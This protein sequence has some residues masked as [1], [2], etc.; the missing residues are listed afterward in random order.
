[1]TRS[2]VL[3]GGGVVGVS[4]LAGVLFGLS[5]KGFDFSGD[6]RADEIIGT[7]AGSIIGALVA[8][9][10]SPVALRALALDDSTTEFTTKAAT[11]ID[12]MAVMNCFAAWGALP[13][14][15]PESLKTV[16]QFALTAPTAAED[17]WIASISANL[18]SQWPASSYRCSAVDAESGEYVLWGNDSGVPLGHAV[19]SSCTVPTLFPPVTI[20]GKRYVDGGVR[21][22]TCADA[23][24]GSLVVILAPIGSNLA[25]PMD[26]GARKQLDNES[27][28]LRRGGAEV[29]EL[30]P[31]AQANAATLSTPLGRMDPAVRGAAIEHGTRQ[32]HELAGLLAA[33]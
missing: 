29:I 10:T 27:A 30:L 14:S 11:M 23:A 15:S 28:L 4:W 1:M 2:L 22:G 24:T 13:D 7:S 16:T 21:S 26:Q 17:E 5:E 9:G 33:W 25:D 32:G 3:G 18:P 19:A 31:D 6:Q 8:S 12:F 20:N